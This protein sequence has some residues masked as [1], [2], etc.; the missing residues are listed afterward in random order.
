M[1]SNGLSRIQNNA[2]VGENSPSWK[3]NWEEDKQ[4]CSKT[5]A[6]YL[7]DARKARIGMLQHVQTLLRDVPKAVLKDEAGRKYSLPDIPSLIKEL[8]EN[9]RD[10][11]FLKTEDS[12]YRKLLDPNVNQDPRNIGDYVRF[13][14]LGETVDDVVTLRRA[15]LASGSGVTSYKDR[16]RRP[17]EEGGHRAFLYH[18]GSDHKFEGQI[19]LRQIEEFGV[20]KAL[21]TVER[22]CS[23]ASYSY[24][25][26]GL[27]NR[28]SGA[29]D[30]AA[31]ALRLLRAAAFEDLCQSIP[32]LNKLL[33]SD[34]DPQKSLRSAPALLDEVS[35]AC[36]GILGHIRPLTDP[37][38]ANLMVARTLQ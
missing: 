6:E 17:H 18:A 7:N 20:D 15:V 37:Q 16:F 30:E 28:L 36:Q 34:I 11:R 5:I 2:A 27:N 31:K 24:A 33:D 22:D 12:A 4:P 10:N 29:F 3:W 9:P 21:R 26:N 1:S 32:G 19:C 25:G 13:Q 14:I 23:K 8:Q 38:V 35:D